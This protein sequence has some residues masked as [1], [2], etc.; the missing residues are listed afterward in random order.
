MKKVLSSHEEAETAC[1]KSKNNFSELLDEV[2]KRERETNE[3]KILHE[4]PLMKLKEEISMLNAK[5]CES[6]SDTN[7]EKDKIIEIAETCNKRI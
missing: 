3:H 5:S 6:K 7:K 2:E 4:K 1:T